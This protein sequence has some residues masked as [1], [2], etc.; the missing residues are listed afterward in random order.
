MLSVV[1]CLKA[2][3]LITHASSKLRDLNYDSFCIEND[4]CDFFLLNKCRFETIWSGNVVHEL[5]GDPFALGPPFCRTY[6][7]TP[8][9]SN[10]LAMH[11]VIHASWIT[12]HLGS[13]GHLMVEGH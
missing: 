11:D 4:A 9:V 13:C 12:I 2:M 5:Q 6:N 7:T 3:S 10:C 1:K 8:S